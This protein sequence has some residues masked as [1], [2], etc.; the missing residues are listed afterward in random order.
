MKTEPRS[1]PRMLY[2]AAMTDP[3]RTRIDLI[4]LLF[5]LGNVVVDAA[6]LIDLYATVD[7]M[8]PRVS[9]ETAPL[10]LAVDLVIFTAASIGL[11]HLSSISVR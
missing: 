6:L 1:I 8:P 3:W 4:A 7:I 5:L 9:N 11:Y 2:E 10:L